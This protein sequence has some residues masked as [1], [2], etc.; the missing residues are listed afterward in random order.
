MT[1]IVGEIDERRP[2]D[3]T[4]WLELVALPQPC[5]SP[6]IQ[7]SRRIVTRVTSGLSQL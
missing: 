4:P 7:G 2:S 1:A 3:D 5:F 6:G